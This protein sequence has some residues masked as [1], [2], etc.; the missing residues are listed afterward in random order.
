MTLRPALSRILGA[1]VAMLLVALSLG[2]SPPRPAT[3]ATPTR[4]EAMVVDN[5]GNGLESE[6]YSYRYSAGDD[7]F[8][9]ETGSYDPNGNFTSD[10]E[11][12]L[13]LPDGDYKFQVYSYQDGREQWVGGTDESTATVYSIDDDTDLGQIIFAT[14]AQVTGSITRASDGA[15][16][17]DA[18]VEI[19]GDSFSDTT[20]ASR[21][22]R[23]RFQD[24]PAGD[25]TMV[26]SDSHRELATSELRLTVGTDD[27]VQDVALVNRPTITGTVKN[28]S[29]TPLRVV[30]V[31]AFDDN[32]DFAGFVT[33]GRNGNYRLVMDP[34]TYRIGFADSLG[35]YVGTFY[36]G[37]EDLDGAT[38]VSVGEGETVADINA[39][40]QP[41]SDPAT[42]VDLTGRVVGTDG[43][44]AE[45]IVA[46][47][48]AADQVTADNAIEFTRVKRSGDYQFRD[49]ATGDYKISFFD[50]SETDASDP[51]YLPFVGVWS[52]G[53]QSVKHAQAIPVV[54]NAAQ[55]KQLNITMQR[56][57]SISGT[58][59]AR[60]GAP[61][62]TDTYVNV[63]DVDEEA[64]G[65]EADG[66]GKYRVLV[67]P[68]THSVRFDA[69][70]C[71]DEYAN[72]TQFIR[73]WWDNSPTQDG[74]RKVSVGS[75]QRVTGINAVLTPDLET[76]AAP[77]I[78]G[79]P[80]VGNTLT[81]TTGQWNLMAQNTY[82]YT[83]L[84]GNSPVGTGKTYR[85]VAAD[86]GRPLSVRVD[87]QH[88]NLDGTALSAPVTPK[89][90]STTSLS[91]SSPKIKTVKLTATVKVSGVS[92]PG[93]TVTFYRGAKA[94]K[95][96]VSLTKGVATV[97]VGSQPRGTQKF[98]VKYAGDS[99]TAG[100][101]SSTTS[102]KIK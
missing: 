47:A 95:S 51:D 49:L 13:D 88:G 94:I 96:N 70:N 1:V 22:G 83:W 61:A 64:S 32:G 36:D 41:N 27:V 6:L 59:L 71:D 20:Y 4:C 48:Y 82:D 52:G 42:D 25:Y 80:V 101:S 46:L 91:G 86:A 74:A 8:Q 19:F 77:M 58:V 37:S 65:G 68:G 81:A 45:G 43:A 21:T 44:N 34:G 3:A 98:S 39:T 67:L 97:T 23:Y 5:H 90:S 73:E 11:T 18:Q 2:V 99:S 17:E 54:E 29:G 30:D 9:Y 85:V 66:T 10:N 57:G 31:A 16:V 84:R 78:T 35:D 89:R 40:L 72:C 53:K 28:T 56:F 26:V 63:L 7:S 12:A 69:A 79:T 62:L 60:A 14:P 55:P 33:T 38:P 24:V 102:V 15:P 75:A 93:G 87:A 76:V 100:S 50:P 92:S